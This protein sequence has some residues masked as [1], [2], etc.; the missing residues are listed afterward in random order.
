MGNS[1]VDSLDSRGEFDTMSKKKGTRG[2]KKVVSWFEN[3]Q[4]FAQR[5]GGSGAGTSDDRGDVI[6]MRP[7]EY[8]RSDVI[9]TEVKSRDDG[10][11]RF[12]K[13]EIVQ[14]ENV[15]YL[16]GGLALYITRPDLRKKQHSHMYAFT[17]DQLKENKKSYT[18]VSSMLPGPTI[19]EQITEYFE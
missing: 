9:V 1:G 8:G 4:W 10:T 12:H 6:A 7:N 13:D 2:E 16:S 3:N 15:A 19:Q 18:I 5:T 11:V 14:L 17:K